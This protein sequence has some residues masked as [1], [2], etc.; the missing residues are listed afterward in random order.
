M[1]KFWKHKTI[2]LTAAAV[3]LAGGMYIQSAMAYFTTYVTA[4]GSKPIQ[5]GTTTEVREEVEDMTKHIV[6]ANTGES[7][8]W[9]RV[10][11]FA[12]SQF[13]IQYS[14]AAADDGS[15]YWTQN[16]DGYWYYKD[17]VRTG[18]ETEV[19][20]AKIEM[21]KDYKD[22][23]DVVVVQECTPVLYLGDGSAAAPDWERE[24]DT[25]TDIGTA[26]GEGED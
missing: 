20:L 26:G 13:T 7:D 5:L 4:R 25:K 22:S 18:E 6:I 16:Q 19:L 1:K 12:G 21:P 3:I 17:I 9:V 2:W 10:K 23:F 14:G 15:Q 11:V 8:C 24:I